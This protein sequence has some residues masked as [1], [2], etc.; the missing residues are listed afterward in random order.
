VER[1]GLVRARVGA[2][3]V[4]D[5]NANYIVAHPGTR[6]ADVIALA[7]KMRAGVRSAVGV[8]LEQELKVW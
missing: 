6:A 7:D 4:S 2:A 5:R 1:A 3:E 8:T